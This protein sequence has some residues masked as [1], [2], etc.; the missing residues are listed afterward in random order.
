MGEG[1][2]ATAW[3]KKT[4]EFVSRHMDSRIWER[5]VFRDDDVIVASYAK[6][7]TTWV[8]QIV[9]QLI[10]AASAEA[11]I[12]LISPWLDYR[13]TPPEALARLEA[14][15]HRR[16]V[17]THLPLDA[18]RFS[19][20]ARY[21]YVARDGRDVLM[22]LHHH[23]SEGNALWYRM[24][25][26]DP[27]LGPPMTPPDPDVRRYFNAWLENDGAPFWPYFDNVASWWAARDL[28]NVKLVHFNALKAD[29]EGE[30]RGIADFL[31][32]DL[33]EDQLPAILE[34]CSFGYMKAHAELVAPLG[35]RIFE[36]GAGTFLHE[37]ANGRWRAVLTE[38]DSA[39]YEARA[40]AELGDEC[41]QWLAT[42]LL[43]GASR[44]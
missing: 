32:A 33:P 12:N 15:S 24:L 6:S 4:R 13:L 16:L 27:D 21:L 34:H 9:G 14:Q 2:V 11:P 26:D 29:L 36:N 42:G 38:A 41:A 19:P 35:G 31:G 39:A 23:H 43:K 20:K 37:G 8:Q 25:N 30:L 5:F 18:L 10:H 7:G 44:G 1:G 28:P 17:K 3:P 22:S 40:R